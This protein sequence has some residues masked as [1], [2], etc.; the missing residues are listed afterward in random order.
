MSD[1]IM[2]EGEEQ[3]QSSKTYWIYEK[4]IDNDDEKVRN[5][6]GKFRGAGHWSCCNNLHLTKK[7]SVIF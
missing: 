7:V 3:F 2:S 1:L 5:Q 4:L 6:T